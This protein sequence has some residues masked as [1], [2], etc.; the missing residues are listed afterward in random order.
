MKQTIYN[1]GNYPRIE[2]NLTAPS[3]ISSSL[4]E[5]NQHASFISRGLGRCYG[6]SALNTSI[7]S[8]LK[9]NRFI[10]FDEQNGVLNCEAG[11]SFDEILKLIV[12]KG[13]FLPITPGTKFITVG[14]AIASDVHGKNHH[15][16]GTFSNHLIDFNI[17]LA[18]GEVKYCSKEINSELFWLTCGGMG[19]TG[20]IVSA[21]FKL[22]KIPSAYIKNE[23]S[24]AQNLD[25]IMQMFDN[26]SDCSMS[27]AWIDCLSK[28][29]KLGRSILQKGEFALEDE[30]SKQQS[31]NPFSLHKEGKL[32]VP[33]N[34]PSFALNP[35]SV[36]AFNFLY[37]NKQLKQKQETVMHYDP[38]FYPLDAI[39]HWNR[40]YGKNG[41][42]QYQFVL[43]KEKSREGLVEILEYIS[44][45]NEGSFLAVLKLFGAQD[46]NFLRFPKEG[47]TLALDFKIHDKLWAFLDQLDNLVAKYNG[48]IYL[49]K[50]V[51]MKSD[52]LFQSYPQAENFKLQLQKYQFENK[53][54]SLQ[55]QRLNLTL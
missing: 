41:F 55:S 30:L 17:I 31:K 23:S 8:S 2:A 50:D 28:G 48:R 44:Q 53:I 34:F 18:N 37:Y 42:T 26:A 9:L 36:K 39:H 14:G 46:E 24:K 45:K 19:L 47:Y 11:V 35:L 25:E 15:V 5:V 38:F 4:N 29:K 49:T 27:V 54:S 12:P 21:S 3:S 6:D 22:L 52:F 33:F 13:F 40:I 43:P 20:M 51:R 16:A 1:W 7:I 32:L 10:A